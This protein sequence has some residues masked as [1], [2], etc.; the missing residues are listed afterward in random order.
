MSRLRYYSIR[1][2]SAKSSVHVSGAE[3]IYDK[4]DIGN[5]VKEYTQ[6]ALIHEKG[7]A[8]EIRLTVEELKEKPKKVFS[9][10]LCTLNT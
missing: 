10:P 3:G 7:R 5:I 6:R 1:M 9:L 8:D 2:R 4:N